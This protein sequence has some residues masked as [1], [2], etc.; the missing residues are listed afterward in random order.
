[1]NAKISYLTLENNTIKYMLKYVDE[2]ELVK[3]KKHP[4]YKYLRQF[5]EAQDICFQ[6]FYKFYKRYVESGRNPEALLPMRRGPE[7]KYQTI[8]I[9]GSIEDKI[10]KYR[11]KGYNRYVIAECFKKD[12]TIKKSPS[13]ST[14]YR[15][16]KKYGVS[17]LTKQKI[18]EKRKIEREYAGSLVHIDC[19]HLPRGIVQGEPKRRYYTLGVIDDFSRIVWVEVIESLKAIDV[20][21]AM[22][23]AIMIMNQRYGI[24]F[25]EVMTD[26]GSEFCGG[27]KSMKEHPFERLLLHFAIKHRKTKPYRP[28]TNGKIERFWRTFDDEVIEGSMFN[29]LDDLKDAVL[30]YNFYYNEERPHQGLN[31]KIPFSMLPKEEEK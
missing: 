20:T 11:G 9:S 26:N 1:M 31:G 5:F 10:L 25:D 3:K 8:P 6:N 12:P 30:G 7:P 2:Y 17:K 29:T 24:K 28:Q 4:K 27:V 15:I 23:D 22:M 13:A 14:I 19:H 18:E 16:L 21:F